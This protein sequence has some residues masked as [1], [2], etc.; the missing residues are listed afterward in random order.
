M[1]WSWASGS[2]EDVEVALVYQPPHLDGAYSAPQPGKN[3]KGFFQRAQEAFTDQ[4]CKCVFSLLVLF[5]ILGA[6]L[7]SAFFC[8]WCLVGIFFVGLCLIPH[9]AIWAIPTWVSLLFLILYLIQ[10]FQK[11]YAFF[12]QRI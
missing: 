5:V 9:N 11:N 8:P 3:K 1:A 7:V 12:F 6:V 10:I 4:T 2:E